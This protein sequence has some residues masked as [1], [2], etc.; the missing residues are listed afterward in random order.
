MECEEKR[1]S[2][3]NYVSEKDLNHLKDFDQNN[4]P[5][6]SFQ[7][8]LKKNNANNNNNN[9]SNYEDQMHIYLFK[10][11]MRSN[12]VN[13]QLFNNNNRPFKF[14]NDLASIR[15][16][17]QIDTTIAD[18]HTSDK[19]FYS[20][21]CELVNNGFEKDLVPISNNFSFNQFVN[22]IQKNKHIFDNSD[23]Y[24]EYIIDNLSKY[25]GIFDTLNSKLDHKRHKM[26][27]YV[28]NDIKPYL[29][30]LILYCNGDCVYDL[31]ECQRNCHFK[32]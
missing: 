26:M 30:S 9:N 10:H 19:L 32:K 21:I 5:C 28:F 17:Q 25:D 31:S 27:R 23:Q 8:L 14:Y 12:L 15:D 6:Q 18:T 2:C 24:Y 29:L 4:N 16:D 20:L 13:K 7:N 22:G 1:N 3:K 11:K